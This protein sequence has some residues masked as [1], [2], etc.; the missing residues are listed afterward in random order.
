MKN[1]EWLANGVYLPKKKITNKELAEK[2][3]VTEEYI[4]KRTGIEKR[5]YAEEETI[6]QMA[7]EASKSA[8]KKANV[9]VSKI[10]LIIVAT[11]STNKLMPGISYLVQ[12]E[13]KI[14]NCMCFD[15]LAGCNGYIN[16]IDIARNHI[17]LGK[18]E[19]ALVIGVDLLSKITNPKDIG[20]SIILSD[21]A[22]A[23]ILKASPK[24]YFS[25][26]VS[27][28]EKGD[29]LT[30]NANEKIYMDGKQVYKYAVTQTVES[31]N[32]VLEMS[33]ENIENID[34]IIP[35]QS[36]QKIMKA[37][38]SRLKIEEEK[39]YTNI[40]NVR[41]YFLCKHTNSTTWFRKRK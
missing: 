30:Y 2:L 28:G 38:T 15:I 27:Q 33:G 21:G 25:H 6:E 10:G 39:M 8:V 26:I 13:L 18:V 4:Y 14:H 32:K 41:K 19:Y 12:K 31:I 9:D 24:K 20:T 37:I 36:N 35:H 40:Q 1:I 16:S 17:A 34:M 29:I 5:Y 7:V 11:T 3:D 22:G 23:S